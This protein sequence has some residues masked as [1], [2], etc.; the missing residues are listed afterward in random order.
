MK[1]GPR[2][3]ALLWRRDGDRQDAHSLD[4]ARSPRHHAAR[5]ARHLIMSDQFQ[6]F[7]ID[8][9][10]ANNA[11]GNLFPGAFQIAA[12]LTPTPSPY[13]PRH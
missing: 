13:P 12:D 1:S 10:A 5:R 7:A 3:F 8:H 6:H 2:Y 9:V 11:P 4:T